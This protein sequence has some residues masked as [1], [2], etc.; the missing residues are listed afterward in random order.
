MDKVYKWAKLDNSDAISI[1]EREKDVFITADIDNSISLLKSNIFYDHEKESSHITTDERARWNAND[2][3]RR[4]ETLIIWDLN[5]FFNKHLKVAWVRDAVL[6]S[7]AIYI[8]RLK[9]LYGSAATRLTWIEDTLANENVPKVNLLF[10][11]NSYL[12]FEIIRK[13]FRQLDYEDGFQWLAQ[14]S[15]SKRY[16]KP[17]LTVSFQSILSTSDLGFDPDH[18][19][20][21]EP[22]LSFVDSPDAIPS[23]HGPSF[24]LSTWNG[25]IRWNGT[26]PT[27]NTTPPDIGIGED[28]VIQDSG[29]DSFTFPYCWTYSSN[30]QQTTIIERNIYDHVNNTNLHLTEEKLLNTVWKSEPII[31]EAVFEKVWDKITEGSDKGNYGGFRFILDED[32]SFDK[33]EIYSIESINSDSNKSSYIKI[34]EQPA[35]YAGTKNGATLIAVSGEMTTLGAPNPEVWTFTN[36]VNL[37]KNVR[38]VVTFNENMLPIFDTGYPVRFNKLA[39]WTEDVG[40]NLINLNGVGENNN[41]NFYCPRFS[42]VQKT[43]DEK[44]YSTIPQLEARIA[45]LERLISER[46]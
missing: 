7:S 19:D 9:E 30:E 28:P 4:S 31:T 39:R 24:I 22:P 5:D 41:S 32:I 14:G 18:Y 34:Y 35:E 27:L 8:P 38:Y 13:M 20:R 21:E 17:G 16:L 1:T 44:S 6:N 2:V 42:F 25:N 12:V 46:Q 33:L 3:L 10:K 11:I 43:K 15:Y 37:S 23:I 36:T 29:W 45:E 40:Y 26:Y